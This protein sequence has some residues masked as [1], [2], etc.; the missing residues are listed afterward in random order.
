M[1]LIARNASKTFIF[2]SGFRQPFFSPFTVDPIQ[3]PKYMPG[4]NSAW[5]CSIFE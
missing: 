2:A 5:P 4:R 3:L 1:E